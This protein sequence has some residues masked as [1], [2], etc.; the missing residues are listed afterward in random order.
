V[1][2]AQPQLYSQ[3]GGAWSLVNLDTYFMVVWT[4]HGVRPG[5]VSTVRLLGH[6]VAIR[7]RVLTYLY[8]YGDGET[9]R[10]AD[11]GDT[12]PAG[13]VRHAY[14][15]DGAVRVRVTARYTADFAIDSGPFRALDDTLDITGP[16]R[17]LGIYQARAHLIPNP[18]ED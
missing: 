5:T 7:P 15:A 14:R 3:P 4:A 8:D 10:T 16:T 18:G 17:T 9:L 6:R 2:F 11:P 12:Y 13:R 1:D